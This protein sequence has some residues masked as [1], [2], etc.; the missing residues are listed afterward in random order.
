VRA[1][2]AGSDG[3]ELLAFG[4]H[5]DDDAAMQEVDWSD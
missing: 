3:L 4:T 2:A 5:T 1:F